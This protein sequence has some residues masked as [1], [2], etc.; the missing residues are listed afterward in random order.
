MRITNKNISEIKIAWNLELLFSIAD[1][2]SGVCLFT[3]ADDN[4]RGRNIVCINP[5]IKMD[6]PEKVDTVLKENSDM[7]SEFPLVAGYISYDYKDKLE[8][9]G[10]YSD[11]HDHMFPE[12][13]FAVYEYYIIAENSNKDSLKLITLEFDS[14]HIKADPDTFF[15]RTVETEH[16]EPVTKYSDTSLDKLHFEQG[17]RS[18]KN[19]IKS[20]DIYQ[21]NLTRKISGTTNIEPLD[22]ALRLKDSN[23]IEFGVFANID[24]KYIISTS[25]ERFFQ[26]REGILT[27]EPI[28]GTIRR[29]SDTKRDDL[30]LSNLMK[31]RKN[32]AELAMIVDLLRNDMNKVCSEVKVTG[33]PLSMKLKNVYHLYAGI[34]G[35]LNTDSFT[36]IISA[37]FPGGSITG[38]PKIR[39]CQIIEELEPEGRG[40][41]TGN[42][43]YICFNGDMDFNIMIRTLL[44]DKGK[45]SFSVGGGITLLSNPEEEFEETIHKAKNIY[46]ASCMEEIWEERYCLTGR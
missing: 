44:Y 42:Y 5:V 29:S 34:E 15:S 27:S 20:G 16:R 37:L 12:F 7:S 10:L 9:P 33:F 36:D 45:I 25:P 28:K 14:S 41:Y 4:N 1:R 21:V 2:F 6:S 3:S 17:V 8:E 13:R 35:K 23:F 18:I 43:G 46:D 32:M 26:I 22:L 30:N 24:G 38:C 31:S 39:A 11:K 19:Y 40:P